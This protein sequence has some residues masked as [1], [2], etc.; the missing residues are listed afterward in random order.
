MFIQKNL[1]QR[2]PQHLGQ[3]W[4]ENELWTK[5]VSD[6]LKVNEYLFNMVFAKYKQRMTFDCLIKIFMI[7]SRPR[8]A[9]SKQDIIRAVAFSK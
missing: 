2:V 4:R 8:M 6:L 5:D 3:K 1:I 7:D 9:A